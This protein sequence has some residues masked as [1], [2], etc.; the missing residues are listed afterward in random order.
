M[1]AFT[2]SWEEGYRELPT[3]VD[4]VMD[5]GTRIVSQPDNV[6]S[7]ASEETGDVRLL[8]CKWDGNELIWCVVDI[9][10]NRIDVNA[11]RNQPDPTQAWRKKDPTIIPPT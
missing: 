5:D 8:L 7:G 6:S 9:G 4:L 2:K 10:G 3:V 11:W 1:R